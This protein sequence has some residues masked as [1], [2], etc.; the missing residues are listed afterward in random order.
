VVED[1]CAA[2]MQELHDREI[3]IMNMIYASVM[4]TEELI[5]YLP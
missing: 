1:A 4:S 5:G 3:E 2:G